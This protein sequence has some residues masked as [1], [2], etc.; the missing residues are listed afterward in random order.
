MRDTIVHVRSHGE[1]IEDQ[2]PHRGYRIALPKISNSWRNIQCASQAGL[3]LQFLLVK[4]KPARR[5]WRASRVRNPLDLFWVR[6][7]HAHLFSCRLKIDV[8]AFRSSPIL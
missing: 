5:A 1:E 4:A 8:K 3:E 7:R 6:L 2:C